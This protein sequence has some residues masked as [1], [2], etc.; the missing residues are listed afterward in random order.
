MP[1]RALARSGNRSASRLL[2]GSFRAIDG[3][4]IQHLHSFGPPLKGS[5]RV[6]HISVRSVGKAAGMIPGHGYQGV[7]PSNADENQ[8]RNQVSNEK[9][10]R[11][12]GFSMRGVQPREP[13][14]HEEAWC[15]L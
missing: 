14:H 15:F 7:Y 10:L 6:C 5:D 12:I 11:R 4:F 13:R 2:R 9:R 8:P 1:D 3:W